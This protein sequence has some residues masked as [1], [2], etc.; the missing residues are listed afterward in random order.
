ML[1]LQ[2]NARSLIANGQELKGFICTLNSKPDIVCVQETWLK[3]SLDFV[4]QGYTSIHK[5]R[6][7]KNGGGC[8]M[9][10]R[11]RI[12]YSPLDTT[13]ELEAIVVEVWSRA[14]NIKVINF[15]NPCK[16]LERR[17]LE[18]LLRDWR[19]KIVWC[20][21]FNAHS[22]LWGHHSGTNG[23]VVENV[24]EEKDGGFK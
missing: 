4:I 6:V 15:Y 13:V 3:P 16:N 2:W 5:D 24:V 12:K 17:E 9:S 21:D 1:I 23:K 8:A 20:E 10:V 18:L 11:S 22:T 19:G 7:G 14:G